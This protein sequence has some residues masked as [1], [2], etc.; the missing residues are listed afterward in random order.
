MRVRHS[1]ALAVTLLGANAAAVAGQAVPN[2]SG[3]WVLQVDKSDFGP[4]PGPTSRTDVIDHQEPR[5]TIKRT[6]SANG[7]ENT[8]NLVYEINGQPFKNMVGTNEI[9]SALHWE[10]KVL[11]SM[12][13]AE[14]PNGEI[15]IADR[16][17]LSEDGKT[18]TQ[19]RTLSIQGQTIPQTFVLMKQP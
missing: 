1:L 11:V 18:L 2:L 17:E 14:T 16:Y 7:Q 19:S 10:G 12:S 15:S 3:T 9:T 13:T 4:I 5:L 8:A 6:T